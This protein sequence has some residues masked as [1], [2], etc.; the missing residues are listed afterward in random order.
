[1]KSL[2]YL[3][4]NSNLTVD[5]YGGNLEK[6]SE[7][8]QAYFKEILDNAGNAG[9]SVKFHGTYRREEL[10]RLMAEIDWV[11]VPSIWWE[12][13]PLVIQEAFSH[14]RPVICSDIGGMAEKVKPYQSGLHFRVG[15]A[16]DLAN[17][18]VEAATTPDLWESLRAGI[19]PPPTIAETSNRH[20]EIY[21]QL[22][23]GKKLVCS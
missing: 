16:R 13:S 11:I 21:Q 19:V 6:Q 8:Y 2:T 20:L 14:R 18:L 10:P 4:P 5:I 23:D 22:L 12:N 17:R 15:N 1:L 3:P 9:Q 7:A